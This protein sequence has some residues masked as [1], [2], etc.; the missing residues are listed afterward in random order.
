MNRLILILALIL[1]ILV[2]GS[3]ILISLF[4]PKTKKPES[5]NPIIQASFTPAPQRSTAPS[6]TSSP[7]NK[8]PLK[9]IKINPPEDTTQTYF[10]IKQIFFTFNQTVD[11]KTV[12]AESSPDA[13]VVASLDPDDPN[14]IV[15]SPE[16]IWQPGITT[17]TIKSA[18]SLNGGTLNEIITY[19]INT[20]FP[21]NPPADSPGL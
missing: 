12:V 7:V 15:L 20:Q 4:G 14:T 2:I 9:L 11:Y 21:D 17:I 13:K 1:A 18:T 16:R 10:P 3:M 5:P 6:P 19:K 8:E